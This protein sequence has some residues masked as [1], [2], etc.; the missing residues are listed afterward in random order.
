MTSPSFSCKKPAWE[1]VA[2]EALQQMY[3]Q[4]EMPASACAGE[5]GTSG[6]RRG[7]SQEE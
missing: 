1:E 3:I 4:A 2:E 6:K 7:K 5:M